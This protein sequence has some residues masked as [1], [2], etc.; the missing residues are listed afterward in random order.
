MRRAALSRCHP[1]PVGSLRAFCRYFAGQ[2]PVD[3]S[4]AHTVTISRSHTG[5]GGNV[6]EKYL[7][8]HSVRLA[9]GAGFKS[10]LVLDGLAEAYVHVTA[11]KVS[12]SS[13][14]L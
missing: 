8:N 10:L 2:D 1:I 3:E 11:I 4:A 5:E 12:Q 6:V 13:V 9:G 7:P 14:W